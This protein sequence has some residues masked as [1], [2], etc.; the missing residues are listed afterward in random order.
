MLQHYS[1]AGL[2]MFYGW[3][4][5]L[6]PDQRASQAVSQALTSVSSLAD[7]IILCFSTS[8]SK[9]LLKLLKLNSGGGDD[10]HDKYGFARLCDWLE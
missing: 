6:S 2:F 3:R 5:T 1:T 10:K 9:T 8:G 4:L 7:P